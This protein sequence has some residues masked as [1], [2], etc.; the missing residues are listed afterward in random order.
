MLER[1]F[2]DVVCSDKKLMAD[3]A[4]DLRSKTGMKSLFGR[5]N[6]KKDNTEG[7][8]RSHSTNTNKCCSAPTASNLALWSLCRSRCL[9]SN[10]SHAR[11]SGCLGMTCF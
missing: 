4:A 7:K 5:K 1:G 8:V 10:C 2:R 3:Y 6:I 11:S 9:S